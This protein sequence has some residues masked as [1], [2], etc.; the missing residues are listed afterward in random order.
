MT[1]QLTLVAI[2]VAVALAY[3][4]RQGW[5]SLRGTG[6]GCTGCSSARPSPPA[7]IPS[8]DLLLRIRNQAPERRA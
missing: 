6:G 5:R 3:L 1:A 2:V 7:L 4:G 8:E